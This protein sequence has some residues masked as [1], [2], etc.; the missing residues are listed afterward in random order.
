MARGTR[1][2]N[3]IAAHSA[4][5][6]PKAEAGVPRFA[7]HIRPACSPTANSTMHRTDVL[8]DSRT[9][10]NGWHGVVGLLRQ[11]VFGPLVNAD[12]S[13]GLIDSALLTANYA[14]GIID[15]GSVDY[16]HGL[17]RP[18]QGQLEEH[19]MVQAVL[20]RRPSKPK[21]S[22]TRSACRLTGGGVA[23]TAWPSAARQT[24][25]YYDLGC[26]LDEAPSG[27]RQ[28]RVA[29]R[30]YPR[31]GFTSSASS[32]FTIRRGT[33]HQGRQERHQVD[34]A[35]VPQVRRRRPAAASR[36]GL[37]P[38]ISCRRCPMPWTVVTDQ[39][40][41]EAIG[42]KNGHHVPDGRGRHPP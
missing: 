9:G 13:A 36:A 1:R 20:F 23:R 19:R 27:R 14:Q 16:H 21:A 41:G 10:K 22:G 26:H 37:Q 38:R 34:P 11:S 29:S 30:L 6:R 31:V 3:R 17:R 4:L 5:F 15:L 33:A 35:V 32:P 18:R 12:G 2:V 28:G 7:G 40:A 39:P 8:A 24:C 42:A 25:G